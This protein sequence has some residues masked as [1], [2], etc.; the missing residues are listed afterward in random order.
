[1]PLMKFLWL[2]LEPRVGKQQSPP[3]VGAELN[4][5]CPQLWFDAPTAKARRLLGRECCTG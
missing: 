1:M 4:L 5:E 3:G 2:L